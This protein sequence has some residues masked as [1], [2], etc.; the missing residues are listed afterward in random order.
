M[1]LTVMKH[2]SG[3]ESD[4]SYRDIFAIRSFMVQLMTKI[5]TDNESNPELEFKYKHIF[6]LSNGQ[7]ALGTMSSPK[8]NPSYCEYKL[9]FPYF[10]DDN[11][12]HTIE[13]DIMISVSKHDI[14]AFGKKVKW[15]TES[16][17]NLCQVY[18][19]THENLKIIGCADISSKA[20]SD[21]EDSYSYETDENVTLNMYGFDSIVNIIKGKP[22]PI[23][24]YYMRTPKNVGS[25]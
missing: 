9:G 23:G 12:I 7:V 18:N 2:R 15:A 3:T 16:I 11:D 21:L 6:L 20:I 22:L 24:L 8:Y 13:T 19:S 5:V 25:I 14:K 17:A 4:G 1:E 10:G